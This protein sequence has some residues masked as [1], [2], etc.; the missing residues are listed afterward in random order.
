MDI[1]DFDYDETD[2]DDFELQQ[3]VADAERDMNS[4]TLHEWIE[5]ILEE[6]DEDAIPF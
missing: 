2:V 5:F 6:E 3:W 1:W 4:M